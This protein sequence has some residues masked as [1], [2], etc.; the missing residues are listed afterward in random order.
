[1][2]RVVAAAPAVGVP[3]WLLCL[4]ALLLLLLS[5]ACLALFVFHSWTTES[6]LLLLLPI[7]MSTSVKEGYVQ[8]SR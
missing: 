3:V 8:S 6:M 5:H 7:T 1:M 2:C 4:W